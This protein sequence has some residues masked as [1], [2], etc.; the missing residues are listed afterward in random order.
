[1]AKEEI[2]QPSEKYV[3]LEKSKAN[4][5]GCHSTYTCWCEHKS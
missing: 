1:M 4:H 2:V 3:N 5:D